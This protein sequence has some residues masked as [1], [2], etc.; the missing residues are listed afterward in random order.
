MKILAFSGSSRKAS[1]N[2][3]LIEE[4]ARLAVAG[5]SDVES[6]CVN[7]ADYPMP[8]YQGDEEQTRGLPEPAAEFKKLL[9]DHDAFIIGNPEYNG[10]MTPLLLNTID[11]CTRS[12]DASPDLSAFANKIVLIAG[13][14]PSAL[15]ASRVAVHLR[16]M[17]SGIGCV[18][19]PQ[20]FSVPSGFSAFNP[21]GSFAD[22]AMNKRAS[23]AMMDFTGFVGKLTN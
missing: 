23:K 3:Q 15:G 20:P 2:Q 5:N 13:T 11:W 12:A 6:R 7:L 22:Q 8:I 4:L 14:S 9:Q 18:V 10:F 19:V 17:L 1:T 21:D 16:T